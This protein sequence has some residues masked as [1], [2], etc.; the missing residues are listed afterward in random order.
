M[1]RGAKPAKA[2][3]EATR[4]VAGR[5]R[6]PADATIRELETRLAAAASSRRRRA[7]SCASS[8]TRPATCSRCWMP[9]PSEQPICARRRSR[10]CCLVDG[11]VLRSVAD[12]SVA[13]EAPIPVV[14]VAL[15]RTSITGRAVLD[16][17]IVH[18]ADIVPLL[19]TEFPDARENARLTGFRAVLAVPLMREAGANGAIFLWRREPGLFA[20]DQ[21]ALV[22]TFARQAAIAIDN[23]RLFKEV[24]ARN[25]DLTEALEQQTATSEILRAIAS[26]PTDIQPVLET[27]VRAAA[28]FCG[29]PDVALLRIDGDVLRGAAAVGAF[30]EVLMTREAG[31][32]DALESP[33]DERVGERARGARACA[34]STST[35]SRPRARTSIRSGASSS[36]GFGHRT[37]LAAP[38][39]REDVAIGV[40]D[41]FRTEVEPFSDKQVELLKTFADQAV[42]AIENVRLFTE[43]GDRNR[44]LTEA[45]EQQTATSE[46]LRVISSSPTDV[47]PVFDIIARARGKAVRRRGRGGFEVRRRR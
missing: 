6:A 32:I 36:A 27:V 26:S 16:G 40:I 29:A 47:Q 5:S 30:A 34:A 4:P 2:K 31:R 7:R 35:T 10:A 12:Y 23:A 39:L 42:I 1:D 25:R 41:L 17:E 44:D 33:A 20:P 19:D 24:Q 11:D 8:A 46:I 28:R 38:L 22:Q 14:P 3:V 37:M 43:L 21:V 9:S 45:L 18:H 13:G 15:K